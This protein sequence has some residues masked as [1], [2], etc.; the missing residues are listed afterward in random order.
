M[1]LLKKLMKID[2]IKLLKCKE[3]KQNILNHQIYLNRYKIDKTQKTEKDYFYCEALIQTLKNKEIFEGT[4]VKSYDDM[5]DYWQ[6]LNYEERKKLINVD[7][8]EAI[9]DL[10]YVIKEN[11]KYYLPLMNNK[12]NKIY[13][14]E[15]VLFELKQYNRLRFDCKEMI[16]KKELNLDCIKY[17]FT[18]LIYID[19]NEDN[20]YAYCPINKTLY[21]VK[22][23]EFKEQ[24]TFVNCENL[25]DLYLFIQIYESNDEDQCLHYIVNKKLGSDKLNKKIIK[26][27]EKRKQ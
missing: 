27:L 5:I 11:E 9:K 14:H 24:F 20:Y 25:N 26:K 22:N 17:K 6:T 4:F 2:E 21:H 8:L 16:D 12:I 13:E 23:H 3:V 18:S 7:I 1:E 15:M 10:P 19:G